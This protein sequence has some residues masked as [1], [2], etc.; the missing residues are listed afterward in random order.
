MYAI[1]AYFFSYLT[2]LIVFHFVAFIAPTLATTEFVEFFKIIIEG[3]TLWNSFTL[4]RFIEANPS[5]E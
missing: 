4:E 2:D 3:E 5:S 1:L